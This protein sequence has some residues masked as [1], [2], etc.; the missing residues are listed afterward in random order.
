LPPAL[1]VW[2]ASAPAAPAPPSPTLTSSSAVVAR[3][4]LESIPL[5]EVAKF[6]GWSSRRSLIVVTLVTLLAAVVGLVAIQSGSETPESAAKR[7]PNQAPAAALGAAATTT[8]VPEPAATSD[9]A[10]RPTTPSATD[11]GNATPA[12]PPKE[13]RPASKASSPTRS[14]STR[15]YGI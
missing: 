3:A 13:L 2:G 15:D 11:P 12:S 7:G 1:P 8:A 10:A 14:A 6:R 4:T 5:S 9:D